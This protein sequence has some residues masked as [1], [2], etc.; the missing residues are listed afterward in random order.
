MR[1]S[2]TKK[3]IVRKKAEIDNIFKTGQAF[4][5]S[6]LRVVV[7][8]NG[9]G[10]SRVIVIPAKHFGNSVQ[11]NRARRQYKELFRTS[12]D[13]ISTGFDFAFIVYKGKADSY[14]KKGDDLIS[15]LKQ[16]G[17]YLA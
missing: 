7:A 15:L 8:S 16:A 14:E 4:S 17:C 3:E 13:N 6:G 5:C 10:F 9:L 12:K 2:L 11:R 1:R